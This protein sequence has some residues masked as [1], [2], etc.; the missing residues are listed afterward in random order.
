LHVQ[1]IEKRVLTMP[2]PLARLLFALLAS[3]WLS[4]CSGSDDA[5]NR[6]QLADSIAAP[7]RLVA[8]DYSLGG[9]TLRT[10]QRVQ[11]RSE[12]TIYIE[13]DGQSWRTRRMPST[14]P[15]PTD[16][17]ALRL[18]AADSAKNV[19]YIARPCQYV[20]LTGCSSSYWQEKRFAPEIIHSYQ[21]LLSELGFAR[22]H[23]VGY[24][25]GAAVALLV[26]A[27]RSDVVDIR[28]V[29]GNV[30]SAAFT[31][32]HHVS[33]LTGS[34]EPA[35]ASARLQNIPQLHV[36]GGKDEVIVPSVLESYRARVGDVRCISSHTVAGATHTQGWAEAW[37]TL[38]ALPLH[39]AH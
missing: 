33:P 34:L 21:Q 5:G 8:K 22:Y 11:D 27:G 12:A 14:N 18:A 13:G 37:P 36:L 16:P 32:Y 30:D 29:A 3:A 7:A 4:A 10:Y 6:Q 17:V 19:I 23:L 24:S 31:S 2:K 25:G 35:D 9:F 1:S 38:L 39:C 20:P 15:T 28:T 26:A